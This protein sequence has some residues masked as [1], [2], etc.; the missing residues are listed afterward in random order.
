LSNTT[1]WLIRHGQSTANIGVWSNDPN[2]ILLTERGSVEAQAIADK[3]IQ[4]PTLI[5]SSPMQRALQTA[6]PTM[7][8]WPDVPM[9]IWPIQEFTYLSP[10]TYQNTLVVERKNLVPNY[11]KRANPLYCD[12]DQCESF[13]NFIQRV[14]AFQKDLLTKHG[15][16]VI[17]GHAQFFKA[18]LLGM[19]HGFSI[20]SAGMTL[21]R[22]W[23]I[24]DPML[25]GEITVLNY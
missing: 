11:W 7:K 8:K 5:I 4:R 1:V 14:E 25:N 19:Q 23:E 18:L 20:T 6:A 16:L 21:F 17:F 15:F 22:K 3:I 9:E 13:S 10:T 24:A 2:G 12:G